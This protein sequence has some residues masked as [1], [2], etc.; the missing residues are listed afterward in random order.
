M[1]LE[2]TS[3]S[4]TAIL[5]QIVGS[6]ALMLWGIRLIRTGILRA[7]GASLRHALAEVTGNRFMSFGV[8]AL[9]TVLV[10]SSTATAMIIASLAAKGMIAAPAALAVMLGAD[11]GTSIAAQI[12]SFDLSVASYVLVFVGFFAHSQCTDH[13]RRQIGRCLLGLGLVLLA[14]S[15]VRVSS[16]PLRDSALLVQMLTTLGNEP[17]LTLFIVAVLTWLVHSSL[18]VVLLTT[19]LFVAD[20]VPVEM[21][22]LMV[23]GANIGGTVPPI[24]ATLNASVA[25]RRVAIGNA[26]FKLSV[27]LLAVPFLDVLKDAFAHYMD[28][29]GALVNFH[30]G[31]NV[32]V[33]L[34]FL[35]WVGV[36]ARLFER[37]IPD[38]VQPEDG[39]ATRY[40]DRGLLDSPSLALA[41]ASRELNRI[42]DQID[43]SLLAL[44]A[45]IRTDDLA[46][47]AVAKQNHAK[48]SS[49]LDSLK[50]YLSEVTRGEI[51][52]DDSN[53]AM[54]IMLLSANMRHVSELVLNAMVLCEARIRDQAR[55][56]EEGKRELL[57]LLDIIQQGLRLTLVAAL[58]GDTQIKKNINRQRKEL[59]RLVEASWQEHFRRLSNKNPSS[60]TT[61]ALHGDLLRDFTRIFYHI[62][63]ASKVSL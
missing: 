51:S 60:V 62:H 59:D 7:F 26:A 43:D 36:F 37:L 11:V 54:N 2:G 3:I 20:V 6:V 18:A 33:A 53:R 23:L 52:E 17:L 13:V 41:S 5:V 63:A 21:G 4:S 1:S 22:M 25:G 57:S 40:L 27:C 10:Q 15:L 19:S 9:I 49:T 16:A 29:A 34:L 61:S 56:S 30:A 28:T 44:T 45:A 39:P 14:L 35:P 32:V 31:L 58:Q 24:I 12:L 50:F 46:G 48:I 8:G 55:F 47:V 38:T 42:P